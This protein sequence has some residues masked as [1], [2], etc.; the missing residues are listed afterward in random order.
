MIESAKILIALASPVCLTLFLARGEVRRYSGFFA[1]GL[2]AAFLAIHIN[3]FLVYASGTD[4]LEA[5]FKLTPI[6]EEILKALPVFLFLLWNRNPTRD[7]IASVAIAVGLGFVTF[8]NSFLLTQLGGA[9]LMLSLVRGFSAGLMHICC[10]VLL[11]YGL[12]LLLKRRYM[13]FPG[14]FGLLCVLSVFHATYNLLVTSA[15][16]WQGAGYAL[17]LAM[18]AAL[19]LWRGR[20]YN[21]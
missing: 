10:A 8:E 14:V 15:S 20:S 9:D 7:S 21:I 4:A 12:A 1:V 2:A 3:S 13:L 16:G 6:N 5:L 19:I 18:A 17:P 11:S